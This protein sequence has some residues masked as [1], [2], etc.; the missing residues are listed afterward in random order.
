[1]SIGAVTFSDEEAR[2]N[3]RGAADLALTSH[4]AVKM[5]PPAQKRLIGAAAYARLSVN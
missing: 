5:A 3:A 2:E 1:M 4:L